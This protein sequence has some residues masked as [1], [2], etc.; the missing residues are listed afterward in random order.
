MLKDVTFALRSLRRD[1][2]LTTA[3]VLVLGLG[4]GSVTAIYSVVDAL[5]VHPLAIRQLDR[6]VAV[7]SNATARN[8]SHNEL[9]GPDF[10]DEHEQSRSF[11]SLDAIAY[12]T[13]NLAGTGQPLRIEG[14]GV[15]SSYFESLGAHALIGRTFTRADDQP[16]NRL[17]ILSTRLWVRQFG[18]DSS[19]VGHSLTLNGVPYTVIGVAPPGIEYPAVLDMWTPL[20]TAD[21]RRQARNSHY[22]LA[23]GRLAPG[24]TLSSA[25]AE[26]LG[27]TARL[28]TAYPASNAGF[29]STVAPLRDDVARNVAPA[30]F[31]LGASV[32]VLLLIG[33]TNVA[34]LLL[35]RAASRQHELALR[36]SLGATRGRLVRQLLIEALVL[37][38]GGGVLGV[39][40][41]IGGV[42]VAKGLIPAQQGQ[43]IVGYQTLHAEPGILLA[44]ALLSLATA[45]GVGMLPA[46]YGSRATLGS[47]RVIGDRRSSRTRQ[48]FVVA[49][50]SLALILLVAAGLMVKSYGRLVAVDPGFR[51]DHIVTADVALPDAT[52]GDSAHQ[53]QFWNNVVARLRSSPG[54]VSAAAVSNVPLCQCNA[55]GGFT[56]VGAPAPLPGQGPDASFHTI[57]P[58]YFETLGIPV[59]RGR[60]IDQHDGVNGHRVVVVNQAFV[61]QWLAGRDPLNTQI[62]IAPLGVFGIVGVVGNAR[63]F[64]F[65][66]PARAEM[67]LPLPELQTQFM[68]LVVRTRGDPRTAIPALHAAVAAVDPSQPLARVLTMEEAAR[69]STFLQTLAMDLLLAFAIVATLLSGLGIYGVISYSVGQRTREMG[70]RSALGA[71][72]R[73]LLRV[74]VAEGIA[75]VGIGVCVGLVAAA[76]ATRGLSALLFG[77]SPLDLPTFGA[78]TVTLGAIGLFASYLPARRA[79]R[80]DPVVALRSE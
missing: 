59:R 44:A 37:A 4:I 22:L 3:A 33:C 39:L 2:G 78:V 20:A 5:V 54:I 24:V 56:I 11:A 72:P 73:T 21:L 62:E 12:R 74:V 60:D 13:F 67:F 43:Y 71:S 55:S 31:V 66:Q 38:G 17:V 69:L 57:V 18:A 77:V 58:G 14:A 65:D 76:V 80:V 26:L 16:D 8:F 53:V 70:I 7:W 64:G 49:E 75:P 63:H 45:I 10:V 32:F 34:N 36:S 25:R 28:E 52:Y 68:T 61:D 1:A 51:I 41:A 47:G 19:I 30:L 6:V 15:T 79:A 46:L 40:I 42:R 50:V 29:S 35:T 9:S 27:I 23:V 48:A